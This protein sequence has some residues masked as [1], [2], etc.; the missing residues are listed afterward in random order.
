MIR[1]EISAAASSALRG[2]RRNAVGLLNSLEP[3]LAKPVPFRVG[4]FRQ[5]FQGLAIHYLYLGVVSFPGVLSD[6]GGARVVPSDKVDYPI[7]KTKS[8]FVSV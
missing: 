6:V 4:D 7:P 3:A 8:K 1:I 5:D 2:S